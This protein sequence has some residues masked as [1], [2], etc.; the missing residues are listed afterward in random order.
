MNKIFSSSSLLLVTILFIV[1]CNAY[2][3]VLKSDDLDYKYDKAKEYYFK[4]DYYR[5]LPILE[6][7]IALRKGTKDVEEMTFYYSYSYYGQ[8][9]YELA[10]YHFKKFTETFPYGVHAEEALYMYAYCYYVMTP[11]ADLDV[12]N[13]D[14]AIDAFQLFINQY[15]E[16]D[17]VQ[18]AN[19]LID[20]SRRVKE[21]K[22]LASAKLYFDIKY[23]QAATISFKN[24]IKDF[25][26]IEEKEQIYFLILRSNFL[27]ASNSVQSKKLERFQDSI[28]AYNDLVENYP[29]SE[30]LKEAVHMYDTALKFVKK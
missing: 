17:R 16:S 21:E 5:A 18:E 10:A 15:P 6:E 27:L 12:S 30:Y 3:K 28:A 2:D 1:G 23:Y 8:G 9:S 11:D 7:L 4:K 14:K 25:P 24:I 29:E 20:E 26:G 22:A 19:R 13:A